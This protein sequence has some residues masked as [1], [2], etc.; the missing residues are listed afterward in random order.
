MR[1]ALT[2]FALLTLVPAIV[3]AQPAP[4][5]TTFDVAGSIGL[6]TADRSDGTGCCSEW[7]GSF[8]RGLSAG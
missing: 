4:P 8:F 1:Q 3:G 7:S 2:F 6:F 5:V